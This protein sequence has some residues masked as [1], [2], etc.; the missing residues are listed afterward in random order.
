MEEQ[1]T[2]DDTPLRTQ[3]QKAMIY[4]WRKRMTSQIYLEVNLWKIIKKKKMMLVMPCKAK[5][6][7]YS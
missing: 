5:I 2:E 1:S 4:P 6:R 7:H 3:C